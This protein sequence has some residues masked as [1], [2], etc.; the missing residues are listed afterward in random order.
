[1]TRRRF[2]A[3]AKRVRYIWLELGTANS[4][5]SWA[6]SNNRT[7]STTIPREMLTI[8]KRRKRMLSTS[9]LGRVERVK[10]ND[11]FS[12]AFQR[13]LLRVSRG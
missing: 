1:M 10:I 4:L 6:L 11:V 7:Y 9:S 3:L 13:I 8:V 5:H 2:Q 12:P